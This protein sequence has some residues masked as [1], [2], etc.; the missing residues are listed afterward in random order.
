MIGKSAIAVVGARG[1]IVIPQPFRRDL[2]ITPTT[3]LCVYRKD[4]KLVLVKLKNMLPA[5]FREQFKVIDEKKKESKV[6]NE[7][8]KLVKR[9]IESKTSRKRKQRHRGSAPKKRKNKP[10]NLT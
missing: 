10:K 3:K 5:E 7:K 6:E 1:Q 8:E 9:D 4:D 2:A